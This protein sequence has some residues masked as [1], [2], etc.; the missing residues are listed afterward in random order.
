MNKIK[1]GEMHKI[2][3]KKLGDPLMSEPK[4]LLVLPIS[5]LFMLTVP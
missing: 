5:V 3:K 4:F 1:A 2:K